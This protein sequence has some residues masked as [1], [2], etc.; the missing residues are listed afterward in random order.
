M[1]RSGT[2]VTGLSTLS[3]AFRACVTDA[4]LCIRALLASNS[5]LNAESE[6]RH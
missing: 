5:G 1:I 6:T 3:T 2:L 4:A